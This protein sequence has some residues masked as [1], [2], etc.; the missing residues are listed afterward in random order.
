M[1]ASLAIEHKQLIDE[2]GYA[3]AAFGQSR[4]RGRIVGLLLSSTEPLSLDEITQM[5]QVSKGPVSMETRQLEEFG[6]IRTVKKPGDRK[7]YFEVTEHPF[8]ISA[9]RNLWLIRRN[10]QIAANFLEEANDLDQEIIDRFDRMEKF[11]SQLHDIFA[12][13]IEKWQKG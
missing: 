11:H 8:S 12:E 13:F 2:F 7:V 1:K 10:Q 9:R 4:A 3:Y 6:M 5:L